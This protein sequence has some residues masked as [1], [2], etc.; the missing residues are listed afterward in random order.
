[1]LRTARADGIDQLPEL[2]ARERIDAGGRLVEN[3]EIGI[4]H[5]RAAQADFLLHAA[6]ELAAGPISE[7]VEPGRLQKLVD[8]RAPLRRALAEQAAEEVD[9]VENAERRIEIAAEPLRHVGDAAADSPGDGASSAMLPSSARPRRSGSC[10]RP[11]M[12]AEQRGLADAVRPDQSRHAAG[13]NVEREVVERERLAVAMRYALETGDDGVGHCGSFT[14]S[15]SR[16]G[17]FGIGAD[18][19]KPADAGLHLTYNICS[20]LRDRPGA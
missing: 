7:R 8:A 5:Q 10:A 2:P 15:S 20:E 3:E 6:R 12:S 4:V 13:G 16:P 11:A 1:M 19:A 9:I 18:E 17:N 14:A